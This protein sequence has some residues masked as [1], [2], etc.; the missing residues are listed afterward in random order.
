MY[1]KPIHG[2]SPFQVEQCIACLLVG[3]INNNIYPGGCQAE[4]ETNSEGQ[5]TKR[6]FPQRG[7]VGTAWIR[8][9]LLGTYWSDVTDQFSRMINFLIFA[10]ISNLMLQ[11]L[12]MRWDL[13]SGPV[14]SSLSQDTVCWQASSEFNTWPNTSKLLIWELKSIDCNKM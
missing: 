4:E 5:K 14:N 2:A 3:V 8:Y 6:F 1:I 9:K 10:H 7:E 13:Y 12:L 11:I